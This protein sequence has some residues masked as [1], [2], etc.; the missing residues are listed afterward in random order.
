MENSSISKPEYITLY[1]FHPEQLGIYTARFC[2]QGGVDLLQ[3][4]T[5]VASGPDLSIPVS[6]GRSQPNFSGKHLQAALRCCLELRCTWFAR[7]VG[8]L[9]ALLRKD[10]MQSLV[11][12][13]NSLPF[14]S[15]TMRLLH[16]A[17]CPLLFHVY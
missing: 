16:A 8:I 6:H 17:Y 1:G 7:L 15:I 3:P 10:C 12:I 2:L 5:G 14:C 11:F 4:L 9:I 13:F